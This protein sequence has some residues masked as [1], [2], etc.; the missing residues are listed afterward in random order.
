MLYLNGVPFCQRNSSEIMSGSNE[1]CG[2]CCRVLYEV[3]FICS[4]ELSVNKS[5]DLYRQK[6][7]QIFSFGIVSLKTY[8]VLLQHPIQNTE[9]R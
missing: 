3:C 2:S 8:I 1:V 7:T 4:T 6:I 9:Y 5:N